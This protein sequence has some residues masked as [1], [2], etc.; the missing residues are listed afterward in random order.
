MA[1]QKTKA[2]ALGVFRIREDLAEKVLT[3]LED[4][5]RP[6]NTRYGAMREYLER[7]VA[8]DMHRRE[9]LSDEVLQ[10]ILEGMSDE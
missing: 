7:L 6:G 8:E 2:V 5:M 10:E 3:L 1:R 4:P 9:A